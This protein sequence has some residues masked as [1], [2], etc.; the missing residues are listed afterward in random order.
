M[1]EETTEVAVVVLVGVGQT[2]RTTVE[3]TPSEMTIVVDCARTELRK[4]AMSR[5][6]EGVNCI[7][8]D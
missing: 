5:R 2:G 1:P 4:A 7:L 6:V 8:S 3:V